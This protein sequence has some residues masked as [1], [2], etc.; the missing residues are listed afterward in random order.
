MANL[1]CRA[2]MADGS[3]F[4]VPL[5]ARASAPRGAIPNQMTQFVIPQFIGEE[6]HDSLRGDDETR[7]DLQQRPQG[8][9]GDGTEEDD[10]G[11]FFGMFSPLSV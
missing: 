1:V 4:S 3:S 8:L 2:S 9:F 7:V 11:A 10:H 6:R 5:P